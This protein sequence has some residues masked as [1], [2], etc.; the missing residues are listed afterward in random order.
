MVEFLI[1]ATIFLLVGIAVVLILS[2]VSLISEQKS[3]KSR[4]RRNYRKPRFLPRFKK[5]NSQV[6]LGFSL[7]FLALI[8]SF[9]SSYT[10]DLWEDKDVSEV[11]F[12]QRLLAI[13]PERKAECQ[14]GFS[15]VNL[16][17]EIHGRNKLNWDERAY[18]LAVARSK[19]MYKRDYFDHVTPEGT[20][21]KDLQKEYGFSSQEFL[22]ENLSMRT[23]YTVI[24]GVETDKKVQLPTLAKVTEVV[25]G[26]MNSRGHRYNLLFPN[27]Q[28]GAIG[29]YKNF[30]TFFGVNQ[31][32]F[33]GGKCTTGEEGLEFWR[34]VEKQPDEVDYP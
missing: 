5:F 7:I 1:N 8:L 16:L 23:Y 26:W 3:P 21:A 28:A 10:N 33:G 27:H 24:N 11:N 9:Q 34:N 19:D 6:F 30:C 2:L 29:C 18:D 17:R 15:Y 12:I 22:A 32:N 20:C 31:E 14:L 4:Y 25:D 13:P